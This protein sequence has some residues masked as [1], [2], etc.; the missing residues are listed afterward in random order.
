MSKIIIKNGTI[1]DGKNSE[2][3]LADVV[4]EKGK[5]KA[6]GNYKNKKAEKIIDASG[7]YV[8]PGF[9][10]AHCHSDG[11]W[12][13]F[14]IPAQES[15]IAQ[16][17][18]TI[19]C[20]NDGTSIAPLPRPEAIETIRRWVPV[21]D[22]AVN[23]MTIEGLLKELEKTRL[24]VNFATLVGHTTLRRGLVGDERRDLSR[25]E[26]AVMKNMTSEAMKEGALGFSTGLSYSHVNFVKNEEID[27][28]VSLTSSMGGVYSTHLR[29]ESEGLYEA[30]EE[31]IR[32]SQKANASLLIAHLKAKG[33][34]HWSIFDRT[35]KL[36]ENSYRDGVN[37]NFTV[38]PYS[39]TGSVLYAYFPKWITDGGRDSMLLRLRDHASRKK[40]VKELA[41]DQNDYEN[42]I[43]SI[44][45]FSKS[46]VGK[47][48]GD[49][50]RESGFS[51]EE[52]TIQLLLAGNGH[53]IVFDQTIDEDNM[54]Q[55]VI[56]P[57]SIIASSGAYYNNKWMKENEELVHPRSFGTFP[58]FL[59]Q[60]VVD[61]GLL[62]W[63]EAIYKITGMPAE[64]MGIAG[65]G[66]LAKGNFADIV[67]FDPKN[68]EDLATFE[69]PYKY[70]KGIEAVL[71]N[72]EIAMKEGV[73]GKERLG[74]SVSK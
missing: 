56:H 6:I 41:E 31:A 73:I 22:L 36:I 52:A 54:K 72:G 71:V 4:I 61:E 35:L 64:K 26:L 44:C 3:Y 38:Y 42:M 8:S 5:I 12:T 28:L 68:I 49:M 58:R 29:S 15:A 40:L 10:D 60:F 55:A 67:V 24:G 47:S 43:V 1:V 62:S 20:G 59:K 69:N 27:H 39:T 23:W 9:I 65:R 63:S 11:Y 17:V 14:K 37:V 7:K 74:I 50:A 19:V 46:L 16:G 30:T 2:P 33:K 70:P 45:P 25:E 21:G 66:V 57:L 51:V 48:I 18:T 34:M 32:T 53:V 13:L